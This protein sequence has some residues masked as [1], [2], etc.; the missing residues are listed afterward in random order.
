MTATQPET[1]T[2]RFPAQHDRALLEARATALTGLPAI[3]GDTHLAWMATLTPVLSGPVFISM[4]GDGHVEY[5]CAPCAACG[6]TV[7]EGEVRG[8]LTEKESFEILLGLATAPR[9]GFLTRLMR[10][11][12]TGCKAC[13]IRNRARLRDEKFYARPA[14]FVDPDDDDED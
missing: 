13:D 9:A 11:T 3:A 10:R 14:D 6:R 7:G 8:R 5:A 12:F 2:K 1:A 4:H